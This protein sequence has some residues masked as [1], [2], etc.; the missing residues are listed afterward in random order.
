MLKT[1]F[2]CLIHHLSR[3]IQRNLFRMKILCKF[4][5]ESLRAELG[6]KSPGVSGQNVVRHAHR[7]KH[8]I[9]NK[10]HYL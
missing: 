9:I 8:S 10:N 3:A 4:G 2:Y 5:S 7:K 6:G 1:H